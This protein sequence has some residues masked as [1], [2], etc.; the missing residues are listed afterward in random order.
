MQHKEVSD[1]FHELIRFI[2][3]KTGQRIVVLVDEYDKPII[4]NI[5]APETATELR[6]G[7]RNFYSVL[8]AQGV[9]LRFGTFCGYTQ[10]ELETVFHEYLDGVDLEQV[11]A[12]Y[13]GYNFLAEPVYN[14]FDVLLYLRNRHFKSYWFE[15][16]TPTFLVDLIVNNK[17]LTSSLENLHIIDPFL[18]FHNHEVRQAFND[19]LLSRLTP[20]AGQSGNKLALFE[21]LEQNDT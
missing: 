7:L 14:P 8:K 13:N 11:Q 16:G 4:D 20:T 3:Q 1:Q 9:H 15:T 17:I 12:W 10:Q 21:A 2:H 6:D 18:G 19:A 5:V